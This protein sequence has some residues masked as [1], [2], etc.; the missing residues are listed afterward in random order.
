MTHRLHRSVAA[1]L[2]LGA[3]VAC[4]KDSPSA[5]ATARSTALSAAPANASRSDDDRDGVARVAMRDE[6]DPADPGWAATGGCLRPRGDVG[7]AEFRAFVNSPLVVGF[8]GHSG[9][10]FDPTYLK[11]AT[12]QPILVTN[13]G[14]RGH[15]FTEVANFG[16]GRVPP[17]NAGSPPAP[18]C[19]AAPVIAPGAATI[20]TPNHIGTTRYQCCIHPWMRTVVRT[21]PHVEEDGN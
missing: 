18:E 7:I 14:G 9:W 17:L 11:V 20:V 1:L 3:S 15:T 5:P 4:S 16:G 8:V 12:G 13:A 21:K 6:C 10:R 19:A 2:L